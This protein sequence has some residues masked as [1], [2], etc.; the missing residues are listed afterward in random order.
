MLQTLAYRVGHHS[1]SDD[2]T[3]YR[4]LN[5]IEH[6]KTDRDPVNRFRKWVE[7]NGWWSE[8]DEADLRSSIKKQAS[9]YI[10]VETKMACAN[11][12]NLS[13]FFNSDIESDSSGG[14]NGE[15]TT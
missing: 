10:Y 7:F 13:N 8:R 14:G 6:W 2:S 9:I 1:T 11:V 3:K 12:N 4:S 15:T 5:E